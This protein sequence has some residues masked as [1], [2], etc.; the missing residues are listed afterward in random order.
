MKLSSLS[1][2]DN[3]SIP[4]RYAFG[5]IDPQSHVA[6]AENF[7]PQFSWDDVP[8]G[9]R[10]FALICHDPDVPSKPDD[11][12]QEG[13]QVPADLPRVDFFHW[14]LIDLSAD[15]RDIGEG[16]FSSGITPRGKGG[17]LASG[18]ARQGINDYTSWFAADRDM[19]GDYFGYDGPCPPWNDALPHR[20][21]FTLYALDVPKLAVQGNFGGNDV[22]KALQGHVLAQ[23]SITGV[24]TLNPDLAPKQIGDTSA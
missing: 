21:V 2:S 10:S 14:V 12:N 3:E 8:E 13:R 24:Y 4:D 16:D 15:K 18:D 19:S 20:Y 17:P 7:N 6:L 5:K 11:V 9:T 22:L 1:F 23:A